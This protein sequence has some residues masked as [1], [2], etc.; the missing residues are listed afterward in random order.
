MNN[1]RIALVGLVLAAGSARAQAPARPG[2]APL[3]MSYKSAYIGSGRL[4]EGDRFSGSLAEF[5]QDWR[6]EGR[7]PLGDGR[8]T[9]GAFYRRGD[10]DLEPN[11]LV[12]DTLQLIRAAAGYE[13]TVGDWRVA[14]QLAPSLAGDRYIDK[15]G[16]SL[17]G[18]VIATSSRDARRIWVV[19]LGLDPRGGLPVLPLFGVILRPTEDWTVRLLLPEIGVARKTGLALGGKSEAKAGVKFSGGGYLVSPTFGSSRGRRDLDS[20]WVKEQTLSAEA[21]FGVDWSS[22]RAE[23]SAGWAFLRRYEYADAGVRVTAAGA[24][25]VGLSLSGR[26]F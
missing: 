6:I 17:A 23:L 10:L 19:G 22:L 18:S 9:F 14:T 11:E 12:P 16:F 20:R 2:G 4:H 1:G 24:P 8:L 26:F 3:E 7:H 21:G 5:R 15:R 13:R 25:V